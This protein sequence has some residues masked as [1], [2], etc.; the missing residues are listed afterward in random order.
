MSS[1]GPFCRILL[2]DNKNRLVSIYAKCSTSVFYSV[3]FGN[4]SW[5]KIVEVNNRFVAFEHS[6]ASLVE[7][8]NKL[9]KRLDTLKPM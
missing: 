8:I 3:S 1:G 6:F 5:T 9:A 4:V 2:N 7:H